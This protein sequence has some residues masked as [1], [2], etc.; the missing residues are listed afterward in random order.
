MDV[1]D[2][3]VQPHVV[4]SLRQK[5]KKKKGHFKISCQFLVKLVGTMSKNKIK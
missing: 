4:W 1:K 3:D 2:Y 5:K